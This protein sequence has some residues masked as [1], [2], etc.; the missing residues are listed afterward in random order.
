MWK[1][2]P[3]TMTLPGVFPLQVISTKHFSAF[4]LV[5]VLALALVRRAKHLDS[6]F[7]DK[8]FLKT[9]SIIPAQ[10]HI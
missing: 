3:R 8:K 10:N 6:I 2:V 1:K 5:F 4:Q 9:N 7:N